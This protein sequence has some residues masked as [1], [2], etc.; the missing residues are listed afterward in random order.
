MNDYINELLEEGLYG[1]INTQVDDVLESDQVYENCIMNAELV[2]DELKKQLSADNITLL[3]TYR[4]NMMCAQDRACV[5]SY[6][7]SIKNTMKF[8]N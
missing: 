6:I 8:M 4:V 3:E 1:V 5:I 7:A 2:F